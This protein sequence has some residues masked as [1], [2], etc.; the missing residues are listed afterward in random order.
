MEQP[1]AIQ[2]QGPQVDGKGSGMVWT[3]IQRDECRQAIPCSLPVHRA[4]PFSRGPAWKDSWILFHVF[5]MPVLRTRKQ[6]ERSG[7][8]QEDTE[9]KMLCSGTDTCLQGYEE[10]LNN[11]WLQVASKISPS[12]KPR[13]NCC[14]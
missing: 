3:S 13:T 8:Q 11:R 10:V 7:H 6:A 1:D 2:N 14:I 9:N 4:P 5:R 12:A